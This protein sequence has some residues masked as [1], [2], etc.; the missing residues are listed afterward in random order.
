[1]NLE[2][3]LESTLLTELNETVSC[4]GLEFQKFLTDLY[5]TTGGYEKS[6]DYPEEVFHDKLCDLLEKYGEE[7]LTLP[8]LFSVELDEYMSMTGFSYRFTFLVI[9][10]ESFKQV[11][12]EY[13]LDKET[14]R[15][16]FSKDTDF[17]VIYTGMSQQD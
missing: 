14:K 17:I 4:V 15:K 6:D 3:G 9:D 1:M 13:K 11:C 7:K 5:F 8:L 12:H 10:K 16:C 2:L